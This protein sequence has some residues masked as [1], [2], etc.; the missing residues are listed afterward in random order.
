MEILARSATAVT[1]GN[2]RGNRDSGSAQLSSQPINLV[3]RER[4][5]ALIHGIYKVHGTLP[6]EQITV[7]TDLGAEHT[8]ILGIPASAPVIEF[9][10]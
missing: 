1:F 4:H 5:A 3:S 8:G 10:Q 6:D 2:I 9:M 7:T